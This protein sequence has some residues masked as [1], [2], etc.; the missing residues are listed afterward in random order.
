MRP[1]QQQR[2]HFHLERGDE[3]LIDVEGRVLPDAQSIEQAA[4]NEARHLISHDVLE[5]RIDLGSS[6]RVVD[7]ANCSM[8]TIRFADAVTIEGSA[9]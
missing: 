7:A 8:L 6:I 9:Q 1:G 2:Y 3:V 4:L 5:G